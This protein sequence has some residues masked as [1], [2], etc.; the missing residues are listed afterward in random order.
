MEKGKIGSILY[1][2][3][4]YK[5]QWVRDLKVRILCK[6]E[7]KIEMNSSK[8]RSRKH[9]YRTQNLDVIMVKFDIFDL[10]KIKK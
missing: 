6:Q 9:F 10:K 2:I 7:K 5:F 4:Q 8:P 1:S 3:C